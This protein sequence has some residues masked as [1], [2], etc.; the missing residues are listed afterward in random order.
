MLRMNDIALHVASNKRAIATKDMRERKK[1][2]DSSTSL[3][4]YI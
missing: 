4:K 3:Y 1:T 2:D